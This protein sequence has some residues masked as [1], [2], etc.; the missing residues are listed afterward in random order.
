MWQYLWSDLTFD[1]VKGLVA[2][3]ASLA[4]QAVA[5]PVFRALKRVRA[6]WVAWKASRK[7]ATTRTEQ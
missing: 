2:G 6:R 4:L 5:P 3:G 7:Q 1:F